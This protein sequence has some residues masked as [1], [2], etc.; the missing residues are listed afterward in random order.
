[1]KIPLE[2]SEVTPEW[3]KEVMEDS[4][5]EG[6]PVQV[7]HLNLVKDRAGHLGENFKAK[8]KLQNGNELALFIKIGVA[9]EDPYGYLVDSYDLE[10]NEARAY[11]EGLPMLVN[12]EKKHLG[13]SEL[14]GSLP[15][16][17][18]S[19]H[20]REGNK[21]G[22]CF[23]ME[24]LSAEYRMIPNI[25]GLSLQELELVLGK[26]AR[27]HGLSYCYSSIHKKMWPKENRY[28]Y[29]K[30]FEEM[31]NIEKCQKNF[32]LI[33]QYFQEQPEARHLIP[34]IENLSRS[35]KQAFIDCVQFDERFLIHG[36]FWSNNVMFSHDSSKVKMYDWQFFGTASPYNDFKHMAFMSA[37]P[38]QTEAWLDKLYDAYFNN[39]VKTCQDFKVELPFTKEEF[40]NDCNTKGMFAGVTA[41]V[42][43]F[44][45]VR[46]EGG[47]PRMIWLVEKA[48][49][50]SPEFFDYK[51]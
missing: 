38:D 39:L 4:L 1:M 20:F 3:L 44:E 51:K 35:F 43:F 17:Y 47:L 30:F 40:I 34:Y 10:A 23:V 26:L 12:F 41:L 13:Y 37:P 49:K 46:K 14:E 19:G 50:Y 48:V 18:A 7:T 5:K 15:K 6:G 22:C 25:D 29:W 27:Y 33:I 9:Q 42:L 32:P 2:I 45:V 28:A 24:D 31:P 16:V 11:S 36:D 8:V 21:R